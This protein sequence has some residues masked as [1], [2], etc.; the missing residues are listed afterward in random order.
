MIAIRRTLGAWMLWVGLLTAMPAAGADL[1]DSVEGAYAARQLRLTHFDPHTAKHVVPAE[2]Q[3]L[4]DLFSI[5][6]EASLLN[7]NVSRWF[8]SDGDRGL[9]AADYRDRMDALRVRFEEMETP[10]RVRSVRDLLSES[11]TLQRGFVNDWYEA[12]E[13]GQ[14]F[15]SQLTD[16]NA[17]HEG[18]HRSH[19]I[20]LQAYAELHA[21]FPNI[22]EA[23]Q[24]AFLDHLRAMDLK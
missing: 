11:L 23:S 13:A 4:E 5:T 17:Y 6:D 14:P 18:L 15:E 10:E 1:I 7:A 20:V 16:E 3:F 12:L 22:G 9:H 21:L 2:S 24:M 19:R 8:L